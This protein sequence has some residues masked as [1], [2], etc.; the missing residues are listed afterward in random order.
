[1]ANISDYL[2]STNAIQTGFWVR[3][4]NNATGTAYISSA[5]T[6]AQ[7]LFS[8]SNIPAGTYTVATALSNAGPWTGTGDT[9]YIVGN[10]ALVFNVK[11]YGAIANGVADDTAA[12][13]LAIAALNTNGKGILL[14]PSGS[15]LVSGSLTAMTSKGITIRG[16]GSQAS[17]ILPTSGLTGDLFRISHTADSTSTMAGGMEGLTLDGTSASAGA[18]GVHIG[19]LNSFQFKDVAIQHFNGAGSV[20]RWFD[21][22]TFWT[23]HIVDE[24]YYSFDNSTHNKYTVNGGTTSFGYHAYLDSKYNILSGQIGFDVQSGNPYNGFFNILGNVNGGVGNTATVWKIANGSTVSGSGNQRFEQTTG[25]GAFYRTIASGGTW[26]VS[27]NMQVG[28]LVDS[29]AASTVDAPVNTYDVANLGSN[30]TLTHNANTVIFSTGTLAVGTWLILVGVSVVGGAVTS[31]LEFHLA[32]NTAVGSFPGPRAAE[33]SPETAAVQR[34]QVFFA[35]IAKITTAGTVAISC[36]NNDA[37][38]DA[39]ALATTDGT[40]GFI[41][42]TGSASIRLA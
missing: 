30:K 6:T 15:Y 19:D 22:T 23:E 1:M 8:I 11:D 4:T 41:N 7:G 36:T 33:L 16:D 34:S 27:G 17:I 13:N 32:G 10:T 38:V 37:T 26:A 39:T 12:I 14:F 24:K 20:G 3:L 42:A 5:P 31:K 28:T 9:Q 40:A 2:L 29:A 21:N 35:S 25:T 18:V